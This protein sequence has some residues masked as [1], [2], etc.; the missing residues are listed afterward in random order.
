MAKAAVFARNLQVFVD[1]TLS[2]EAQSRKLAEFARSELAAVVS[3]G[4][5]PASHR[6][7][8]D[9]REG[10][11]EETVAPAPNGRIVYRFNRLGAVVT[12]ALSF[13]VNRSPAKSGRYRQ[14]FYL[15]VSRSGSM[16][17]VKTG[18]T[19]GER[20]RFAP[21]A[22]PASAPLQGGKFIPMAQFNPNALST[23]V[24]EVV[25]GNTQPYSRKV[26]V[27]LIGNE[28]LS[29][30]VPP[31]LFDDAVKAIKAQFGTIVDV[32][33]VYTMN[34]PG[35]YILKQEQY[36]KKKGGRVYSRRRRGTRVESPAIIIT[37]RQ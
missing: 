16:A 8:V 3:A 6:R 30:E 10:A 36:G 13:L 35:Q 37:P 11:Q 24:T 29:F 33:R 1:R 9:G 15:G 22:A 19:R 14:S 21:S 20:G 2:P 34:F 31:G 23:D 18:P 25:I 4:R 17:P 12:F 27:Q 28:P 26:D 7:F 5:A 32:K